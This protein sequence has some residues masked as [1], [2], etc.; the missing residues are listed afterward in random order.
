MFFDIAKQHRNNFSHFYQ[1]GTF[2][3]STDAGWKTYQLGPYSCLYKGYADSAKLETLLDQIITQTEPTLTGNFCVFV[4]DSTTGTITIKTDRYRA[5]PIYYNQDE[6]TNLTRLNSTVWANG[7]VTIDPKFD[8]VYTKFN[9][10]GT[11]D[12]STLS[13]DEVVDAID[14]ILTTKTQSFVKHNDL[15][16][17]VHLSGGVDSL[18]VYS[19][20]QKN[21]SNYEM[22]KC[23]HMDYDPFWLN[24]SYTIQSSYWG[25]GQIHHWNDACILTS[26]APGDEFMLRSP[27][28]GDLYAQFHGESIIELLDTEQW[29]SCLHHDYFRSPKNYKIFENQ[30]ID[31]LWDTPEK[32]MYN[33]CNIIANDWQHWHLGNTM[34]WTPLRDL[35]IF[36]LLLRLPV[37][38]ALGQLMNSDISRR[39][40]ERNGPG[41]SRLVSDRKNSGNSKKNLVDF[42]FRT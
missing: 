21:T 39:L 33:L 25:Y 12:T 20:L 14:Q 7:I 6:F 18:L 11:L 42:L 26:G 2:C 41:L 36:K 22:I 38:S 34:T 13:E 40:I 1:L 4:F 9:V 10:I 30:L 23:E 19:Y 3:I 5:F 37:E 32:L 15:P 28:T 27:T 16:V 35:E 29:Q 24:N 31:L 17:R 8:I